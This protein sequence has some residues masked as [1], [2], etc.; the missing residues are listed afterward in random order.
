MTTPTQHWRPVDSRIWG[1][2]GFRRVGVETKMLWLY[3]LTHPNH[4]PPGLVLTSKG[5]LLDMLERTFGYEG[6]VEAI[7]EAITEGFIKGDWDAPLVLI[8]K[9]LQY[10]VNGGGRPQSPNVITNWVR[11]GAAA[12]ESP[13][14]TEWF[15]YLREAAEF[16]GAAHLAAFEKEYAKLS[17]KLSVKVSPEESGIASPIRER[18]R[19]REGEEEEPPTPAPKVKA[20]KRSTIP[21]QEIIDDLNEVCGKN[22]KNTEPTQKLIRSRWKDGWRVEDFKKVHRIMLQAVEDD[23]WYPGRGEGMRQYLRP[24]TLYNTKFEGYLNWSASERGSGDAI[25]TW[26]G[27]K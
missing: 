1:D 21:Y 18:E 26:A 4:H 6:R 16:M 11:R 24:A 5:D 3:L 25:D 27:G 10:R 22:F 9:A 23:T 19:E 14:R 15:G 13:L 8:P 7:E 20:T 17:P 2:E 12:P